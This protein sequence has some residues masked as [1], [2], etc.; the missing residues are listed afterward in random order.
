[1]E[2]IRLIATSD[3]HGVVFPWSYADGRKRNSGLARIRNL[4]RVMDDDNTVVIDNGDTLQGSPL[5]FYHYAKQPQ[6]V[7]PVTKAMNLIA[8]DYVNLGNHDFD[9]GAD[10]LFCHLDNCSGTCLTANVLYEGKP[11][12][13]RYEIREFDNVRIAFFAITTHFTPNWESPENVRGF[14][15]LDAFETA[16]DIV[17]EIRAN[18]DAGIPVLSSRSS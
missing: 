5:S 1:M 4:V 15:F 13:K 3:I 11:V 18:V 10:A 9:Y 2:R 17:A 16:K 14:T 8:Y 6:D 12:G 7:S